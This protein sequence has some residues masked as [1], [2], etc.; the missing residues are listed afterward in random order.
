MVNEAMI[1]TPKDTPTARLIFIPSLDS[2]DALFGELEADSAI[3][4]VLL[5]EGS[6]DV[7]D[8]TV[9]DSEDTDGLAVTI[10]VT[11]SF[12]IAVSAHVC[13]FVFFVD[14]VLCEL[15]LAA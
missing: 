12:T 5:E 3:E 8:V 2:E 4:V 14:S 13:F 10:T 9:Y 7:E 6:K 1:R 11:L 15:A